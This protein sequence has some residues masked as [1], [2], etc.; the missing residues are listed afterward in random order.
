MALKIV[1]DFDEEGLSASAGSGGWS[2][3][4]ANSAGTI[5]SWLQVD[6]ANNLVISGS[7]VQLLLQAR[8]D[9]LSQAYRIS[10]VRVTDYN[11][12]NGER[13]IDIPTAIGNGRYPL[14]GSSAESFAKLLLRMDSGPTKRKNYWMG[15]IPE[16]IVKA[17]NV[18]NPTPYWNGKL[19]AWTAILLAG[20]Y[21]IN[22]RPAKSA[23]QVITT[24]GSFDTLGQTAQVQP[25]PAGVTVPGSFF[26]VVIRG[27]KQP[28]GWNGIHLATWSGTPATFITIGPTRRS[29]VTTPAFVPSARA[30]VQLMTPVFTPTDRIRPVRI[31][32]RKIGRPFGA[33]VGRR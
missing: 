19:A 6:P 1:L 21:G 15:G 23:A 18:Y 28:R 26:Y 5:D 33:E 17:P 16:E 29:Q 14:S 2:E 25:V 32:R 4:Y 22:G 7:P 12:A 27:M 20:G 9:M 3:F 24:F 13:S 11:T 10:H 8:L 31:S 30:T